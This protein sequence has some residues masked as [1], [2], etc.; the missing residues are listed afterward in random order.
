MRKN[1]LG[2]NGLSLTIKKSLRKLQSLRKK[3]E[4]Q[5][6]IS[7][8]T[9]IE[10]LVVVVLVGIIGTLTTQAF[11][12]GF[13]AQGKSEMNKEVKQNGDYVMSVVEGM[14]RNASDIDSSQCNS[15][16]DQLTI[17]NQDGFTTTFDCSSGNSIASVSGI[18]IPTPQPSPTGL[19]LI[20][21]KVAVVNCNFRVVCPTPPLSP[22]YVFISFTVSQNPPG[23]T[24][25]DPIARASVDYET[26]VSL[27]NY[28]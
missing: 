2:Q 1:E 13:R 22:K 18:N 10:L 19:P 16:V 3:P 11:I 6:L 9:L 17:F 15:N 12:L 8:F 25:A 23:P 27:R 26:T 4:D 20:S 7:G 14:V 24:P 28:Q 5:K 21:G